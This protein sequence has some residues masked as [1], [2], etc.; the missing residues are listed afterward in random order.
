[1][2]FGALLAAL[3]LLG[4]LAG[5]ARVKFPRLPIVAAGLVAVSYGLYLAAVGTW[6]GICW[7]CRGVS[8]TRGDVFTVSAI[9]F[10]LIAFTTLLGVWL[11]ARLVTMVQRLRRTWREVRDATGRSDA[12]TADKGSM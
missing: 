9:F 10:G 7:E 5:V 11:G 2:T 12:T 3:P 4:I 1:M 8:Q 6:A